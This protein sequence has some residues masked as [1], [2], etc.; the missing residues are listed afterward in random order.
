MAR[1]AAVALALVAALA[2]PLATQPRRLAQVLP[3][4]PPR[5]AAPAQAL[6]PVQ[7]APAAQAPA[8]AQTA[9]RP[10]RH[11]ARRTSSSH[12]SDHAP[13]HV[14]SPSDA[15]DTPA[16][17]YARLSQAECEAE[18]AARHIEHTTETAPAVLAPVRLTGALHGVT[19]RTDQ[20]ARSRASS[21]YEIADCRLV[22]AL[23]DF[24]EILARH[25]IVEVR[26]YSIYRPP[27]TWP[28]DHPGT[29]HTGA[30]A[31]DAGRFI[32]RDG[33]VLDVDKDFHGAIDAPTCG[34]GAAPR[35]ATPGALALR[36]ILCEAVDRRLFNVVLT[37]NYN[38]PHH[39]HFHLEITAGVAWFLV[40]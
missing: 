36:A 17:R 26:H 20:S 37:P 38:R 30:L 25:D 35:P 34:D 5:P 16:Y 4:S 29:R 23:D 32:D 33:A 22:L 13:G 40:H 7:A 21:P 31:V 15:T 8:P 11:P 2:L 3:S 6:P 12:A 14:F 1:H 19:F 28:D 24:A 27:K 9:P 10:A 39:N 18:L